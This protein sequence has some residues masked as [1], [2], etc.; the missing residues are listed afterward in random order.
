MKLF[1]STLTVFLILMIT[2]VF[3]QSAFQGKV[4]FSVETDGEEQVMNYLAKDN[5]LRMEV[6]DEGGY[7]LF[8][9]KNSKMYIIMDEQEMYMETDLQ[10]MGENSNSSTVVSPK[11]VRQ[12]KYLVMIVKN[13]R[14]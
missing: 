6:P 1:C 3:A 2:N 9:T 7:I 5:K 11:L 10:G 8:D 14:L 13:L 4:V 12:K